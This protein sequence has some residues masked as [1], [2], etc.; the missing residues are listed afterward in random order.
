[1]ERLAN[2]KIRAVCRRR[3]ERAVATA[4]LCSRRYIRGS[5]TFQVKRAGFHWKHWID[6][7]QYM[8][9]ITLRSLTLPW[10][11]SGSR[12]AAAASSTSRAVAGSMPGI[13][14]SSAA[15]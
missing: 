13:M 12:A 8:A 6:H 14:T 15:R 3:S 11:R 5:R 7:V 2:R 9:Q 4:S 1:M 10:H